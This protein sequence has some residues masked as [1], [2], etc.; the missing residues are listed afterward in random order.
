MRA[1]GLTGGIAS[2]KSTAA[3]ALEAAGVPVVR[4]DVLAR[5]VVA[6]GEPA[7][8]EI[9]AAFGP[10]VL[11]PDGTLLRRVLGEIIFADAVARRTLERITH[12]RIHAR[13]LQWLQARREEGAPGAVCDIP[14]LYE[15]GY[16]RQAWLDRVW[17]VALSP[18]TQ[19]RRLIARDGLSRQEALLRISAQWPLAEKV[20]RADMV[21]D[22]EG[23]PQ[24][25]AQCVVAAWAA[26][27]AE[28]EGE[29]QGRSGADPSDASLP[30]PR[31]ADAPRAANEGRP[32]RGG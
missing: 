6:P 28:G 11:A 17:V 4:S 22:N 18:E 26:M 16:D 32:P 25:L 21:F 30:L 23:S 7:L 15:A 9:R 24:E 20:R 12:P 8:A 13:M 2:G 29:G 10:T 19:L 14:L 1:I 5:E 31:A 3:G 27:L